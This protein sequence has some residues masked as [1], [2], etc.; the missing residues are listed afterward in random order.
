MLK[1][2]NSSLI[3]SKYIQAEAPAPMG[4][5]GTCPPPPTFYGHVAVSGRL[6]NSLHRSII[7]KH[8]ETHTVIFILE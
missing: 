1:N 5:M 7:M 6:R 4:T 2:T 3:Y 8:N